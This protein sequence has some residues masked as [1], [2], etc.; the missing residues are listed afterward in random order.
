[1][2]TF[3]G[4]NCAGGPPTLLK[5]YSQTTLGISQR[6]PIFLHKRLSGAKTLELIL[7]SKDSENEMRNEFPI[8]KV[9][10]DGISEEESD[11]DF[12][13]DEPTSEIYVNVDTIANSSTDDEECSNEESEAVLL[14]DY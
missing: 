13:P 8:N 6:K 2:R 9:N 3:E 1:M 14:C 12:I 10:N 4:L 5:S 11:E 7:A